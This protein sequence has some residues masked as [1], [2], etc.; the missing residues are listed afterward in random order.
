MRHTQ[1]W[2]AQ[3]FGRERRAYRHGFTLI[4]LLVVIAIIAI[5]AGMLL[6]ALAKAKAKAQGILCMANTKQMALGYIMYADDQGG[7]LPGNLDGN[8]ATTNTDW[9]AGWLDLANASDNTNYLKLINAQLGPYIARSAGVF[10]CPADK[11]VTK[12]GGVTRSRV[13]SLSMNA[14]LGHR[15][16]PYTSGYWQF[17][18]I[19]DVSNPSP[20]K[21]WVFL[22]E[23]E[24]SINDG[25]FAVDMSG[26]DPINPSLYHQV[27][28][29]AS[30]HNGAGGLSYLDGHSEIKKWMDART[31]PKLQPGVE[32]TL[33]FAAPGDVDVDWMQQRTSSLVKN[34]TRVN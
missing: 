33:N 30:Y 22:D 24:D 9:C 18:K 6:P 13:R 21:C 12:N 11:S 2:K 8:T 28:M 16:Q 23:R 1:I 15:A 5:L 29:Q 10:K 31:K 32:L 7:N 27:D 4:E 26:Y 25:N 20:S 3:S 34:P 19:G 17:L 14:Y